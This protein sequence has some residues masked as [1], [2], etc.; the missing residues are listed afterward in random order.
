[1]FV[2]GMQPIGAA[3]IG[4]GAGALTNKEDPWMGAMMGGMGAFGGANL[5]SGVAG[6]GASTV[7]PDALAAANASSDPIMAVTAS[8]DAATAAGTAAPTATEAAGAGLQNSMN[9]PQG[10]AATMGGTTPALKA[11]AAA[12]APAFYQGVEEG[13]D[14]KPKEEA[15]RNY[16]YDANP[17]GGTRTGEHESS[18]REWF[19]PHYTPMARGGLVAAYAKGGAVALRQNGFVVPADVV[20]MIG[21]GSSNAGLEALAKTL[22]AQPLDGPGDGLSDDIPA[23]IDGRSPARVA[24]QEAYVAPEDVERAGGAKRLYALMDR[25][26][27]QAHGTSRQQRPVDLREAL[28]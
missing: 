27:R 16:R 2:P 25:V 20:S 15:A 6:M 26:R 22:N 8:K 1:M 12:A 18:E 17:T 24:R 23:H 21:N 4:A 9:N 13:T 5:A 10:L 19:D 11:T 3:A 7:A 28:A 14:G